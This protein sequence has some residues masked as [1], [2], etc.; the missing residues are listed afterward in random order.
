MKTEEL[1]GWGAA[2][3]GV[4]MVV[5][6]LGQSPGG[7]EI[8]REEVIEKIRHS[9]RLRHDDI[10]EWVF[11][12]TAQVESGIRHLPSRGSGNG[13]TFY[14]FGIQRNRGSDLSHIPLEDTER[15]D[16]ALGNLDRHINLGVDEVARLW[17][18]YRGDIDRVRVAWVMPAYAKNG[19]PYP[20]RMGSVP[21]SRR[22]ANWRSAVAQMGGPVVPVA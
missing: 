17:R 4:S 5:G 22:L 10:P 3:L 2:I 21:T 20:E 1:L 18:L 13:R 11:L 7:P 19:P 6:R 9:A 15:L 12:A 16:A 14:P 8:G